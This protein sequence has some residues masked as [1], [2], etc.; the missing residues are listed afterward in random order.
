MN[1]GSALRRTLLGLAA[2]ATGLAPIH[3]L[4]GAAGSPQLGS[5][6][7]RSMGMGGAA[8]SSVRGFGAVAANPAG[9]GMS[10]GPSFSATLLPVRVVDGMNPITLGDLAVTQGRG[11]PSDTKN[12]WLEMV[13]AD[14]AQTGPVGGSITWL[15]VSARSFGL[16]ISTL[17]AADMNLP[18]GVVELALY[19]NAGR[20]GSPT[21]LA[22]SGSWAQGWAVSTAGL[23]FGLPFAAGGG[24]A[25][26]GA[27]LK[28]SLGHGAG[29]MDRGR[30]SAT[31]SPLAVA[32]DFPT[33]YTKRDE[34]GSA[35]SG[36]GLDV[37]FQFASAAGLKLGATVQ[38]I[39]NTFA[40]DEAKLAYRPVAVDLRDRK[41]DTNLAPVAFSQAPAALRDRWDDLAFSPRLSVGAAYDVSAS[42][43]V[44]ADVHR[45]FGGGMGLGPDFSAGFG[46]E[47]HGLPELALRAGGALVSDG[48]EVGGGAVIQAKGLSLSL[49]GGVRTSSAANAVLA[50]VGVSYGAN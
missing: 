4:A 35:G 26:V 25:A 30:T 21:D 41:F 22:E 36:F 29:L 11:V 40:W 1:S 39:F 17:V 47:W 38:N 24:E 34:V 42:F 5:A 2:L 49:A 23:A 18:P 46:G 45:R 33:I 15:A 6:T 31:S 44:S 19:G 12:A 10:D 13:T 16:Q 43:V 20:T 9:L 37:G 48:F 8:T 3:A 28:F 50:M 14:G 32:T 27:T 7:V